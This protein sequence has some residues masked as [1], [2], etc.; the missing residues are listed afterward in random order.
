MAAAPTWSGTSV[1]F[2]LSA[3]QEIE[4]LKTMSDT[5][6]DAIRLGGNAF[7]NTLIGNAGDNVLNGGAGADRLYG[8]AGDDSYIVDDASDRVFETDGG[9]TDMVRTSV[10]FTL[11]A[12]QEIETLRTMSD[13]GLD[14]IRLG[15]NAF[16]NTLIGNAGD[17]VLNGGAGADRLYGYAGDDS[18]IVDDASDRVFEAD[19]GGTDMVR[20]SVSFTLS[21]GQ[22]IETLRTMSDTGLDAIR[23]GGNA[24]ANT[25][26]G[27]AGANVLNGGAGADRLYG[28]AGD[29]SYIVDDASDRVFET[30]GGGTDMVRTSVSFTLSAGQEIETLKTMSDTGLDAIR[31]GGNAFANTL[32][33]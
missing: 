15:G 3:G 23:L 9:G 11:S 1:S 31:L 4:T 28:Y 24:F 14:A 21:A 6:L 27:N 8:Y 19:G 7:A 26:I 13:T 10:S 25:L 32:N 30:D 12:G 5:G 33:R 17:N 20:T 16:A 18:Y 22:E 29:D 2:T